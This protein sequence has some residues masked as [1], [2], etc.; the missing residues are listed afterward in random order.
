MGTLDGVK[1]GGLKGGREEGVC[2]N[3]LLF[4]SFL[5][6]GR[7]YARFDWPLGLF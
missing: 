3:G 2:D 1:E 5:L 7:W 4:L 6:A